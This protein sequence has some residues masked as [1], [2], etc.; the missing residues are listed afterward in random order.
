MEDQVLDSCKKLGLQ[1][2]QYGI[3]CALVLVLG[4]ISSVSLIDI[5]PT[6]VRDSDRCRFIFRPF[7]LGREN[8]RLISTAGKDWFDCEF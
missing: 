2:H 5:A 7:D 4:G 8:Q 3:I 1:W 6:N